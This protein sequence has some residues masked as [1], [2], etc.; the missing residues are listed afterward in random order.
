MLTTSPAAIPSPWRVVLELDER[1]SGRDRHADL[2]PRFFFSRPVADREGRS[3]RTFRV[4]LVRDRRAEE[5]HHR[6]TDELLDRAA[7]ALKL[8]AETS[9]VRGE[10][11]LDILGVQPSAREV[12]P[13][14]SA[15]STVT[16]LRSAR[17]PPSAI[18]PV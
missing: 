16:I 5:R 1:L 7:A 3:H 13:T 15:K 6:V 10:D 17:S 11:R 2:D 18:G 4:I 12:N 9:V 8:A 14:R